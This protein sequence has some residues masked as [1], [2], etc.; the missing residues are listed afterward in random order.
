MRMA[1]STSEANG[2]YQPLDGTP[3]HVGGKQGS[4]L[5]GALCDDDNM[6]GAGTMHPTTFFMCVQ[7]RSRAST[8][9]AAGVDGQ[10]SCAPTKRRGR[11]VAFGA[12]CDA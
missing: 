10:C 2:F 4:S 3:P 5:M 9:A 1:A 6:M 7:R 12:C 8:G 11:D